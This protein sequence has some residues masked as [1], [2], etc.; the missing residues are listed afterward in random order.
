M[1]GWL[2][3][4]LLFA[5]LCALVLATT[6]CA[7]A[8]AAAP[9]ARTWDIPETPPPPPVDGSIYS[10]STNMALFEDRRARRAGDILTVLLVEKTDAAKT[11]KTST[12]K[13]TNSEISNP[14]LLGR[15]LTAAGVGIGA[16]SLDSAHS[17]DGA[18]NSAQSNKLQ[19]SVTVMVRS[20]MNNGNLLVAGEK[21]IVI[22]QGTERISI[23]GLVRPEDI[24]PGNTV[25]SD[26][27]ADAR[28]S[29]VGK[30]A[31]ADAN[32]AGWLQRI[33]TSVFFPF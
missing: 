10:A 28:I 25:N 12:S 23:E 17:F 1:R 9:T 31:I 11:A 20:V 14:T 19:G 29:Y 2:I 33:F 27:V 15:P 4:A 13:D 21:E 5:A 16:F 32:A 26:R 7:T 22:N 24:G 6:G 18:G 3:P 8:P 30:G